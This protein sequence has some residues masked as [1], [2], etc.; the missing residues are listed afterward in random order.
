MVEWVS[1]SSFIVKLTKH[2]P[3]NT[4]EENC[5]AAFKIIPFS[6]SS[7]ILT[8]N[9]EGVFLENHVIRTLNQMEESPG[10]KIHR[11]IFSGLNRSDLNLSAE[12]LEEYRVH[13]KLYSIAWLE[14]LEKDE[15][16][17]EQY[18]EDFEDQLDRTLAGETVER[19]WRWDSDHVDEEYDESS[20]R[21]HRVQ[22]KRLRAWRRKQL[23]RRRRQLRRRR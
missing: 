18:L 3:R 1:R 22:R 16:I 6:I 9:Q 12:E 5:V 8:M 2:K 21:V 17:C 23:R 20:R 13:L 11:L 4:K 7:V 15:A 19:D 10:T 14:R